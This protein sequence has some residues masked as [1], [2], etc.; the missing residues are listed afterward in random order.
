MNLKQTLLLCL[1]V[2]VTGF[3]SAAIE[4]FYTFSATTGAYVHIEGTPVP[5]ICVNDMLSFA[6]PLGIAFPY[7][8]QSYSEI[9]LSSNG[10]VGLGTEFNSYFL[11]NQLSSILANPVLAPLWDNH[12]MIGG[13]VEYLLSGTAPNRVFTVEFENVKW[14]YE[15]VNQFDFQVRLY[16]TGVIEFIYGPANGEPSLPSASIGINMEPGSTGW[17]YSVTPG[18]PATVSSTVENR[19]ISNFPALGT[20]YAFTPAAAH[21][22][23]LDAHSLA[24][25]ATPNATETSFYQIDVR[26]RG[27]ASQANYQVK[28]YRADD[29]EVA[30]VNGTPIQPGETLSHTLAWTPAQAGPETLYAKA[31]LAGDENPGNDPTPD[32]PVHVMP[33]G[34]TQIVV[35]TGDELESM[36]LDFYWKNSLFETLVYPAELNYFDGQILGIRLWNHF[37]TDLPA[38][39]TKIWI[40]TT[41]Q[42]DLS[43]GWIP[44]TQLTLVFDGTVNYPPGTNQIDIPFSQPFVYDNQEHLVIMVNRPMDHLYYTSLEEFYAQTGTIPRTLYEHGD[45]INYDPYAPPAGS[46][47][48]NQYPKIGFHVIHSSVGHLEGTVTGPGSVPLEGGYIQLTPGNHN[49]FTNAAGAYTLILPAGTYAV[50]CSAAGFVPQTVEGVV[51]SPDQTTTQNF[52]LSVVDNEDDVIPVSETVLLGNWPNPVRSTT[53][54]RYELKEPSPLSLD[55]FNTRGQLIRRLVAA[56]QD[57]G[58]HSATWDGRDSSGNAVSSGIYFYRLTAGNYVSQRKLLLTRN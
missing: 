55:I 9:K 53:E 44:A 23:D 35:G 38:K 41:T 36:P 6:I 3:L 32:L 33:P 17:F 22:N 52:V 49:T 37:L 48:V 2:F 51:V 10:W 39:P 27:T 7:G 25:N 58:R 31:I 47:A 19:T 18:P 1:I 12:G 42:N 11:V 8:D 54:I 40:G 28:L 29:Q 26:N 13:N 5:D 16:E 50:T 43:A 45:S 57:S 15:G 30:S 4:E 24:G 21:T 34:A 56:T 46:Q 14:N 20:I